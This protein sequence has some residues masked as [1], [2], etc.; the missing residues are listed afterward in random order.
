MMKKH[1]LE[2]VFDGFWIK[3]SPKL[4]RTR[5]NPT[6]SF[7]WSLRRYLHDSARIRAGHQFFFME[8]I[9]QSQK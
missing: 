4:T 3:S 8:V 5:F 2:F 1:A 7:Y 9:T 6:R